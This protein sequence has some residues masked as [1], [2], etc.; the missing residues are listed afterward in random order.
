MADLKP[1]DAPGGGGGGGSSSESLTVDTFQPFRIIMLAN[2]T[3]KAIPAATP[4]PGA[5][6]APSAQ[7]A[8]SGV[9]LTWPAA[10]V[11]V[12]LRYAVL[13]NGVELTQI[14]ATTYKDRAI[15]AG[16]TYSYA[17]QT[18]DTY[19]QRSAPTAAAVA[20]I[21]PALNV[22]PAVVIRTWPA[23][24]PASGRA[25]VRVNAADLDAQTLALVL[26]VDAGTL[27][28]TQ[29]PSVWTYAA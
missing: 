20:F 6:G 22:P 10:S 24:L 12:G 29:D 3:V 23:V 2:G 7:I 14:T 27:T 13:R 11:G 8:L 9:T 15:T 5:A 28:A 25:V 4:A 21:D 19:G 1:W 16:Q 17:V 26:S 18:V